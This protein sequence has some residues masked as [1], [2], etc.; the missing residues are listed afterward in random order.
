MKMMAR[1]GGLAAALAISAVW[2][3]DAA[4][5]KVY[6][7]GGYTFG[8]FEG[9]N[10][11]ELAAKLKDQAGARVTRMGLSVDE[12]MFEAELR[13]RGIRGRLITSTAEKRG[14]IWLIFDLQRPPPGTALNSGKP[15]KS[16][17]FEGVKQA[18]ASE[19]DA[20]TGL[21]P[22]DMLSF[23]TIRAARAAILAFY[24]KS[25]P[26]KPPSVRS[27]VKMTA[28]G[29]VSLTWVISEQ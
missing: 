15:L 23:D 26:G 3:A 5:E 28:D 21:K 27:K 16:Q 10:T 13:E 25:V 1:A 24:A 29:L 4:K 11:D 12:S 14:T 2:A 6:T 17:T 22:G 9:L 19:L 7:L 18:P 8:G 20:A